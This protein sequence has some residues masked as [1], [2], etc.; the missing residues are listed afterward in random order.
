MSDAII[1][2]IITSAV[3]LIGVILNSRAQYS[4]TMAEI[5]RQ[6]E[7]SD[8]KLSEKIAVIDTE[9]TE[10]TREVRQHN[11]FARRMPVLEEKVSHLEKGA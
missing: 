3:T 10:L 9:I 5:Q 7:L 8:H 11:E 2:A 6:S 1:T 4:K